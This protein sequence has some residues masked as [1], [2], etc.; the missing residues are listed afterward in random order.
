MTAGPVH[1]ISAWGGVMRRTLA[2]MFFFLVA[3]SHADVAKEPWPKSLQDFPDP[4]THLVHGFQITVQEAANQSGGGSGGAVYDIIVLQTRTGAKRTLNDQCVGARALEL[5]KGWPQ[6]ELWGRGGGGS[7]SRTLYRCI[8]HAYQ[9]VRTDEFPEIE[10]NARDKTRTTTMP[11]VD[12][13]LYFVETR[14]P[15]RP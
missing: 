8:G 1:N 2:A 10:A 15:E 12:T 9:P 3:T 6:I 11:K 7:W 14:F 4:G 5:Y 13:T